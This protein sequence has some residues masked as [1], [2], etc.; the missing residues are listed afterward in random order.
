MAFCEVFEC[1]NEYSRPQSGVEI[2][3]KAK[4]NNIK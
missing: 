2:D 1:L 3:K 4:S